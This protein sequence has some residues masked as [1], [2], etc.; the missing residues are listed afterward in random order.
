MAQERE[1]TCPGCGEE[2][3]FRR[4]ASTT[5]HLGEKRKWR[6]DDCGF[7]FVTIDGI[8]QTEHRQK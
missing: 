1:Q 3:T 7:Q 8:D 4:V 2:Q 6:D 5:L